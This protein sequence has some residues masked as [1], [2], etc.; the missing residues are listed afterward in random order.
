VYTVSV[1]AKGDGVY[2]TDSDWTAGRVSFSEIA[3]ITDFTGYEIKPRE[4]GGFSVVSQGADGLTYRVAGGNWALASI[5]IYAPGLSGSARL[6]IEYGDV[7]PGTV[8]A[9]R[10]YQGANGSGFSYDLGGDHPVSSGQT[11]IYG[12]LDRVSGDTFY[13]GIGMGGGSGD[14][15]VTIKSI[16]IVGWKLL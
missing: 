1:R 11:E 15:T 6:H 2:F 16:R 13:L 14:R 3:N 5:A 10:Y 9:G 7:T 8:I 4:G 12:N